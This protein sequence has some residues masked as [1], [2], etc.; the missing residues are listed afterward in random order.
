[1]PTGDRNEQVAVLKSCLVLLKHT[2]E[3]TEWYGAF[4]TYSY[5]L[6]PR[7][8]ADDVGHEDDPVPH[9]PNCPIT[10]IENILQNVY[11]EDV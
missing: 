5:C 1:M 10:V 8:D 6:Y 11:G 3:H 7:C 9:G 2:F 4:P